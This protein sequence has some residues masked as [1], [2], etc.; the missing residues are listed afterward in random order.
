MPQDPASRHSRGIATV[1]AGVVVLSFDALLI[2]L[3]V[4]GAW[5][6][7]FWRGALIALSLL[8]FLAL[9]GD[10]GAIRRFARFGRAG[11]HVALLQGAGSALFVLA[12]AHTSVANTVV[13]IATAPLF[14]AVASHFFLRERI[15]GRT[16]AASLAVLAGVTLVFGGALTPG[17]TLGN[18]CALMA[19]ATLGGNLTLLRRHHDMPRIPLVAAS[20]LVTAVIAAPFGALLDIAPQGWLVLAV[21]GLVQM[22]VALILVTMGTRYLSSPEVSLFL[23]LE[24]L[25]GPLWVWL[26]LGETLGRETLAGGAVILA[27]LLL[28]TLARMREN[29]RRRPAAGGAGHPG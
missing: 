18:L 23:L 8:L 14:A 28:H 11:L 13:L 27:T 1:T 19:A 26:A 17:E 7:I 12:V 5:E 2:R 10:T 3:A 4:A 16:W 15:A 25:L 9:R 21:M 20:G 6:V 22:P 29:A 24:T